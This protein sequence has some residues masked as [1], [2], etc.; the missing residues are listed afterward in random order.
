MQKLKEMEGVCGWGNLALDN[1]YFNL[2]TNHS[3]AFIIP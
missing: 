2:C 1:G 3:I